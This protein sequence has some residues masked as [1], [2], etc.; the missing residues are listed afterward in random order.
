MAEAFSASAG[1]FADFSAVFSAGFEASADSF[2]CATSPPIENSS[3]QIKLRRGTLASTSPQNCL[4]K[5][6]DVKKVVFEL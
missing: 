1:G 4:K 3:T 2:C 5:T 6:P